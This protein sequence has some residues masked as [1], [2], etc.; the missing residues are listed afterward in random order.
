M[1]DICDSCAFEDSCPSS[2]F[3]KTE[4]SICAF[5]TSTRDDR[6]DGSW[7]KE[8]THE[9]DAGRSDGGTVG[10]KDRETCRKFG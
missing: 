2:H 8:A 3:N 7:W 5:Y 10:V 1:A 9:H 6:P 4:S